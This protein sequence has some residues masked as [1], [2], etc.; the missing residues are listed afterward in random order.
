MEG[1]NETDLKVMLGERDVLI[2]QQGKYIQKLLEQV[3]SLTPE[4]VVP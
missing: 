4:P 1:L 2:A 3:K